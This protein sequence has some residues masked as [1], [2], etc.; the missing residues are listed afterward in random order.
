MGRCFFSS[1]MA[2]KGVIARDPPPRSPGAGDKKKIF[3][4]QHLFLIITNSPQSE[5]EVLVN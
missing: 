1:H 4:R 3:Y 2:T 5:E